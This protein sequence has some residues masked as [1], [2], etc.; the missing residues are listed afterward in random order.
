LIQS[1]KIKLLKANRNS[2]PILISAN[3]ITNLHLTP[4][5]FLYAFAKVT[6]S[7][8]ELRHVHPPERNNSAPTGP[9]GLK[10]YIGRVFL[11]C[12]ENIHLLKMGKYIR[13]FMWMLNLSRSGKSFRYT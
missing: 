6:E 4:R 7:Y 1:C 5:P 2:V 8:Y 10:F 13:R 12:V 3:I 11:K 9:T